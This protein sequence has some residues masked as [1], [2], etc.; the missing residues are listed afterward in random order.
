MYISIVRD[1]NN[2]HRTHKKTTKAAIVANFR[3]T[4]G[5]LCFSR[6]LEKKKFKYQKCQTDKAK[7][8][9]KSNIKFQLWPLASKPKLASAHELH[10]YAFP[11]TL[12]VPSLSSRPLSNLVCFP[13]GF[14][15]KAFPNSPPNSQFNN[16]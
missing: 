4:F 13:L 11:Q 1:H 5:T 3:W 7:L 14:K 15:T 9:Q 6:K 2:K 12:Y 8:S 10:F 16:Y